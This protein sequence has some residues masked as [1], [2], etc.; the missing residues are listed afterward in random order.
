MDGFDVRPVAQCPV[1]LVVE[2]LNRSFSDYFVP[3]A[4]TV[5]RFV[6]RFSAEGMDPNSS[7][8]WFA[9]GA[10]VGLA[11]VTRR[12]SSSRLG[13]LGTV[14]DRRGRGLGRAMCRRVIADARSRGDGD[15]TLEV[16]EANDAAVQLYAR[17]GFRDIGT[18][19]GFTY[20]PSN[21]RGAIGEVREVTLQQA[22]SI[23]HGEVGSALPWQLQ[24]DT[25][26][27][28]SGT[29]RCFSDEP[30]AISLVLDDAA[31]EVRVVGLLLAD[32][33][34]DAGGFMAS[35]RSVFP[36]RP[37]MAP[38]VFPADH[39]DRFFRPGGWS[40]SAIR[41]KVMTI[42]LSGAGAGE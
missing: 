6:A 18:L 39:V 25:L 31:S 4:L 23:R 9:D 10:P 14:P 16:I 40:E 42:D 33:L 8:L 28:V 15:L 3:F 1:P 5:D 17:L 29:V 22:I 2:V 13:A 37:W 19:R 38:A 30:N 36:D 12:G 24:P 11:L 32:G 41:Q 20:G 26:A 7:Y 21:D 27:A 35:I 34:I